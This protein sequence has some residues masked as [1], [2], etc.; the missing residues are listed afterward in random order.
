V[1]GQNELLVSLVFGEKTTSI[2]LKG[3]MNEIFI[4]IV[5][6]KIQKL[7]LPVRLIEFFRIFEAENQ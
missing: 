7:F 5:L 6:S 2:F 1:T 4:P 3:K